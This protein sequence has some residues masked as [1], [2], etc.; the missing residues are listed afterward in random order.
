MEYIGT[1][2]ATTST[3]WRVR[4]GTADRD[5]SLAIPLILATKLADSGK[6]VDFLL[7]WNVPHSGDYD[8]TQLFDWADKVVKQ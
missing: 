4:Q 7:P 2:G 3:Y 1:S 5:T 6:S 8:L